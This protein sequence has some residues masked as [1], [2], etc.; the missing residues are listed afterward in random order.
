MQSFIRFICFI[1][2]C[3]ASNNSLAEENNDCLKQGECVEQS[4]WD[5]AVAF[6]YGQKSN[7][8]KVNDDISLYV[9][10]S[11]AYYG[12]KWF[13]DNGDFGYSLKEAESFTINLSTSYTDDRAY[14]HDLDLSNIFTTHSGSDNIPMTA[15][16]AVVKEPPLTFNEL[17]SRHFTLLGGIESYF[18]TRFGFIKLGAA[19]DLFD[20]HGG[21][22]GHLSWNYGAAI[23]N[24]VFDI[25]LK[26]DWKSKELIQYYYG[27]RESENPY[28]SEQYSASSGWNTGLDLTSRY[29]FNEHWEMLM[30]FRFTQLSDA[31]IDSPLIDEDTSYTYFVGAAYRF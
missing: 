3:L 15:T 29:L 4:Q 22:T 19:T 18:Y 11:I 21:Q 24:W 1:S 26:A 13:F 27:V 6:G 2:V 14:F 20:V 23:D 31:I 12:D 17:E 5:I 30:A 28:W 10:P 8:V 9:V 25:A 7:P 16:R